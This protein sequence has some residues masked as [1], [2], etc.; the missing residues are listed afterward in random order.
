[1]AIE[2]VPANRRLVEELHAHGYLS[3]TARHAALEFLNP[4][5]QWHLWV[6]HLLLAVGSALVLSGVVYFFAFNW[7]LIPTVAKFASIQVGVA[8]AMAAACCYG[9]ARIGGQTLM[10]GASVLVGV[11]LAVF[12][13]I[14]QTGADAYA[15]FLTWSLLILGFSVISN[16]APQ[17]ILWLAVTNLALELWWVQAANPTRG[18]EFFIY[19]YLVLLN[20][21][22]L[23]LREWGALRG[24]DWIAP[25]W[26]RVLLALVTLA[27]L[28][29]PALFLVEGIT[30]NTPSVSILVTGTIGLTG[31]VALF[32]VYRR[33]LRDMVALAA[34]TLSGCLIAV[35]AV[36]CVLDDALV[37]ES[38][39]A[40]LTLGVATLLIFA[41]AVMYLRAVAKESEVEDD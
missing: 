16:F 7:D 12:G 41:A 15:L 11:F 18:M 6:S 40:L 22:A 33:A 24:L 25:R 19:G 39:A 10:L 35:W 31:H 37:G 28:M 21:A 36:N 30:G 26:T 20:G 38:G 5:D 1:M 29:I 9:L 17:W 3:T 34:T 27:V 13:Q 2:D 32:M 14:Y 4:R 23:A 8:A